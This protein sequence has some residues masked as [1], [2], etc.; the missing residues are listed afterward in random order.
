MFSILCTLNQLYIKRSTFFPSHGRTWVSSWVDMVSGLMGAEAG[1]VDLVIVFTCVVIEIDTHWNF[2]KSQIKFNSIAVQGA[3]LYAAQN[4]G[5]SLGLLRV[6]VIKVIKLQ[7]IISEGLCCLNW[8]LQEKVLA[9]TACLTYPFKEIWNTFSF[10][11]FFFF[12]LS[13]CSFYTCIIVYDEHQV[14]NSFQAA[15]FYYG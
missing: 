5:S 8:G 11:F 14:C 3:S 15:N 2:S 12:L 9:S 6:L 1:W 13:L 7:L 10:F 4:S